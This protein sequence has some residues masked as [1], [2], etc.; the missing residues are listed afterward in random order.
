[1]SIENQR[2][3]SLIEFAQQSARLRA[4]T[5]ST[6]GQHRQF[7]LYE[8]DIQG[9][10]GIR[11]NTEDS[12]G[13]DGAWVVV[14]RTSE[15]RPP[16]VTDEL[17]RPW[18]DLTRSPEVDPKL[19]TAVEG[20][21]LIAAGYCRSSQTEAGAND[22]SIPSVDPK[23]D[24][25]LEGFDKRASVQGAFDAYWKGKWVVWSKEEKR[26]RKVIR[27]YAEL[28]TLK[29]V[30]EGGIFETQLELV[31]GVGVAR[32][33]YNGT[34]LDYPIITQL[35]E[36]TIDPATAAIQVRPRR[37]DPVAEVDWYASVDNPG[38]AKFETIAKQFFADG[39][40]A[41]SPFD[42]STFEPVL[43]AAATHLDSN[44]VYWPDRTSADDRSLPP[45]DDHLRVSDTWVVFARQRTTNLFVQDLASFKALLEQEDCALPGAI[46]AVVTDP[47]TDNSIIDLPSFRGVSDSYQG[48]K[49]QHDDSG[50][51]LQELYFPKPFN[52]EQVRIVQSL[53]V[54]DGVAVQGP[55]G[56]GK[57]HTIANVIS[58]YL[59]NGKRVLVTSMKDPALVE[60]REKLPEE[61][62]PL[63]IPLLTTEQEGLKL[64]EFAIQKIAA[65]VQTIDRKTTGRDIQRLQETIDAL[66]S[67]L[68][69][70]SSELEG[71]ARRNLEQIFV[72]D[73][74]ILPQDAAREVVSHL[75]ESEW[76]PDA[77][78][79][80]EDFTPQFT[81]SDIAKLREARRLLNKD[82]EYLDKPL[83]DVSEFPTSE[84]L[85][86]AHRDLGQ[87]AALSEEIDA[88]K[89]P[90]L[91]NSDEATFARVHTALIHVESLQKLDRELSEP[92]FEWTTSI[93]AK[94]H[95]REDARLFESLETLGRELTEC[96]KGRE[97]FISQPVSTPA[98]IETDELCLQAIGNL[99]SG[100]SAFGV[101]G[102]YGKNEQK[103]KIKRILITGNPPKT[104]PE[105]QYVLEYVNTQRRLREL[106]Y[107]W[108]SLATELGLAAVGGMTPSHGLEATKLY[109]VVY[110]VKQQVFLETTLETHARDLLPAWIE[111][112]RASNR[113][114]F[115]ELESVLRHHVNRQRL[116]GV[117]AVKESLQ[118]ILQDRN[119]TVITEI[120]SFLRDAFGNPAVSDTNMQAAWANLMSELVRINGLRPQLRIVRDVTAKIEESGAPLYAS[121]LR[122]PLVGTTDR[123]LLDNWRA[124]WRLR[125]LATHLEAIDAKDALGTLWKARKEAET[126]LARAYHDI[127]V[128]RTWL[129][130]AENASPAIRAALQA[131]LGA[132][133]KIGKGTGKRAVRYRQDARMAAMQSNPAV[134]CW[135]MSHHR[136]AETL[137]AEL[138][139]FD[140]VIIDEASQSDLAALPALLRAQKI[141][142]VGDDKQVSPEGVG[143]EEEKV[144]SLMNRF[145]AGQVSTYRPQMSPERSMYDLFKVVFARS[146]VMLREHFRCV[147]PIIEYS[148]REF[149]NHELGPLRV[150]QASQRL[151]PPLIDVLIE[152]GYRKGDLNL[153]E[154]RFIVDE[155]KRIISDK[156]MVDRTIGVVSLLG[157]KQ[158]YAVWK[159]L[160]EEVGPEELRR[161]RIECGDARAFQGKERHIMFLTMV[162]APNEVGAPL[163]RDTFAQ[164]FNVA[165]SRAQDRMYLVRSVEFDHLS[166]ADRLRRG[167]ITH[168]STP[169]VQ[170]ETRVEDLRTLC[171][172]PFE[173]EL[174]DE[175][176]QRGYWVTP[177]VN[178]GQYRIDLV[179]EGNN[180]MRLAVECDGDRYHGSDK[181]VEDMDR[182]R[183]LERAGWT[184]WR[185][186]ASAFVRRRDSVMKE[187]LNA[188]TDNG[189][190]AIGGDRAPRSL[191]SEFRRIT[192][193]EDLPVS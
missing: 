84:V 64:F 169:F 39:E 33:N 2:L 191:H 86:Q 27:I 47:P 69:R 122:Q 164:R 172:S 59:A 32:W 121:S 159:R 52:E 67:R 82:L 75:H 37:A 78:G 92:G 156:A 153:A 106:A 189:V 73:E 108:N 111:F 19:K 104:A 71:W 147:A 85:V 26:R 94:L 125:R 103:D 113:G 188:L 81:D 135:I 105:W 137:P 87:Y 124:C 176:T 93:A 117:W 90:A 60:V 56:T 177:Q 58:H 43:R 184:F 115:S 192:A 132:I 63:A 72:D 46:A 151:D 80:G 145:L 98:E 165:A 44:G 62:R 154:V 54:S 65:E 76:I 138:G 11:L 102:L 119:G 40:L 155:I 118:R 131:Y 139:C 148:K 53:E 28:F 36:I 116:I 141:L 178:V 55:P 166:S 16:D 185:S 13:D 187:L 162:S 134:P 38:V 51:K 21:V 97:V 49:T 140:L 182:Q 35:V 99:A 171:E 29:Q 7:A 127:V 160:I 186:F 128:K 174:Y 144:R 83:P 149:Y 3:V 136:I 100:K 167:L 88:G 41:F 110:K 30:L 5:A 180:D 20:S 157:D 126:S 74:H 42:R 23:Q 77:L 91:V 101:K 70:L 107:K 170:D 66:H 143:L 48:L 57:T 22:T 142:V 146:N 79:I 175:L 34:G 4:K 133:Q 163:S 129:K 158:A 89:V 150:P 68:A 10:S 109:A 31:W 24:V 161:H 179:V 190:E 61:I 173:R 15:T 14:E 152:D 25:T 9:L 168:F 123:L 193:A 50:N 112:H 18:I 45:A 181:W 8:R 17:L 183:V 95:L 120:K 96:A 130:L 6:V 1:M 12:D 114:R